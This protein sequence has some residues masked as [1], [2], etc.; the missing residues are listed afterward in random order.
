MTV[1]NTQLEQSSAVNRASHQ[2]CYCKDNTLIF[3]GA[4]CSASNRHFPMCAKQGDTSAISSET[5]VTHAS[6]ETLSSVPPEAADPTVAITGT[7]QTLHQILRLRWDADGNEE[8]DEECTIPIARLRRHCSSETARSLRLRFGK[9]ADV[10][11]PVSTSVLWGKDVFSSASANATPS[12]EYKEIMGD[13]EQSSPAPSSSSSQTAA[14]QLMGVLKSHGIALVR[15][16]PTNMAG[17]EAL[18]RKIGG[19]LMGTYYGKESWS[20][21]TETVDADYSCRDA[22]YTSKPIALHTDCCFLAEPPG[23][24]VKQNAAVSRWYRQGFQ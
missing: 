17:T 1:S 23:M 22:A 4:T 21:S 9:S 18:G 11:R 14:S 19:H 2:Y 20:V 13:D 6:V 10:A 12:F 5:P 16:V 15:G 24:Q 8:E 3:S 7:D